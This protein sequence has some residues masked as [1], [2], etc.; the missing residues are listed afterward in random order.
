MENTLKSNAINFGL[1]LGAAL[2]I[3]TILAYAVDLSLYTEW[4]YGIGLMVIVIVLGV[5]STIKSKSLQNGFISFK[6]AF[7]SYF[8][9]IAIGL[10]I[11]AV[12]S[13][14]IFNFIDTEAALTIKDLM[15]D[16]QVEMMRNFN[17]PEDA[18][19][20]VVKQSEAQE[21]I[22]S[23]ANVVQSVIFQLIGFS[24]IGLIVALVMKRKPENV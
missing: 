7:T 16:S 22:F 3:S 6:E 10:A 8:I 15:L 12:I 19:A 17:A 18:I 11:S 13:I 5:V 14:V 2:S 20:E 21:N 24:V 1:Y 23:I 4:W 9:T